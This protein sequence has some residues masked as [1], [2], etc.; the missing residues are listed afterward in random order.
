[1]KKIQRRDND[2]KPVLSHINLSNGGV[3]KNSVEESWISWEGVDGDVQRNQ[4]VHG[5]KDRA[6]CLFSLDIIEALREEG[7]PISPGS[8]GENLTLSGFDWALIQLGD[9]LRIGKDVQIEMMSY[10]EP[11]RFIAQWFHNHDYKRI[12]QK[13]YTGWSRLYARVLAEGSIRC[14]DPVW[15]EVHQTLRGTVA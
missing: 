2:T 15:I 9:Q 8:T 11:C 4:A 3:P 5:G 1:M 14:G 10:A 13:V 12:S 6:L 7:H